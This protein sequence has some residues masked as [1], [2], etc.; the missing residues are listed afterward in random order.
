[1]NALLREYLLIRLSGFGH[2]RSVELIAQT[3]DSDPHELAP[4]PRAKLAEQ[5]LD[6]AFHRALRGIEDAGDL[7][8]GLALKDTPENGLLQSG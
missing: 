4:C 2:A 8:V 3:L 1:M 6:G 5:A 7:F